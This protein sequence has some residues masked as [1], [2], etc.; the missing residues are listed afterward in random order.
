MRSTAN[1]SSTPMKQHVSGAGSPEVNGTYEFVKN[2]H[3]NRIFATEA[4]HYQ[5][6]N[7]PSIFI[8][9]QNCGRLL[10][11]SEWN[12]WV[13]F[14]DKGA[15]Y[16][17][18]TNKQIN[19]SPRFGE[20]ET[21]DHWPSGIEEAGKPPAPSIHYDKEEHNR[22]SNYISAIDISDDTQTEQNEIDNQ[23]LSYYKFIPEKMT[24]AEHNNRAIAMESWQA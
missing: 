18:H 19:V 9:F 17:A 4:G 1:N 7:N 2:K 16:A 21:V 24:W 8:A 10:N 12:K 14:T 5:H 15:R 6:T 22:V 3:K 20:W 13:I 11:K 23:P